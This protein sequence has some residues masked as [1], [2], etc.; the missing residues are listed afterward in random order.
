MIKLT[1]LIKEECSCDEDCCSTKLNENMEMGK[2]FTGGGFAFKNEEF[3]DVNENILKQIQQAE[4][5][6]KSMAGNMT[7]AVKGIEKIRRG[8]SRHKRVKIALKKYNEQEENDYLGKDY[9]KNESLKGGSLPNKEKD[10]KK[11]K[12]VKAEPDSQKGKNYSTSTFT[13]HHAGSMGAG[14]MGKIAEPDTY[15]WDDSGSE[16]N[17]G[18]HQTKK[19]KKKTGYEPVEGVEESLYNVS[20]DMKDGKFDVKNPQVHISGYG[21]TNLKTLRD[22][23][24]RK[25]ID[26]AKKAKKGDV[27]N[28]EY[29]L[30][31]NGVLMGFVDA[32]VDANKQLNSSQMKRKITMYKRKH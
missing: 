32:L 2:V 28:L 16:P 23:L 18:G 24:S 4:K 29:L 30:K 20:Q 1:K 21:V 5:I 9:I 27:E 10:F 3:D 31:R 12:K 6:A 14:A 15:D 19:N 17:P 8:L 25:F 26:L 11:I 13:K 22:S 7:G